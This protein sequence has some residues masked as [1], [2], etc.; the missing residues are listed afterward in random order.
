[1]DI[2]HISFDEEVIMKQLRED[3][4]DDWFP[5]PLDFNDF[6]STGLLPEILQANVQL[7]HGNY[8][9]V[10]AALLNV[11][12]PN[13]TLRYALETSLSD[14]AVYHATAMQ[15]LPLFDG[16]IDWRVFSHRMDRGKSDD[17]GHR[18]KIKYSFRNGIVAWG[19]FLGSVRTALVPG[20]VLL[21]TDLANY[22]EN[23]SVEALMN[24][25]IG[26]LPSLPIG[27]QQQ[28]QVKGQIEQTFEYLKSWTY[29]PDRGLPQNRDASSFLANIYMRTVDQAMIG[30]GYEYFRYMDDIKIICPDVPSARLAL[31]RLIL[32]LRPIG[33]SVNSGKTEIVRSEEKARIDACLAGGSPEMQRISSAW[34]TK[35]LPPITR[36]FL[37]LKSL[38]LRVLKNGEFGSREFRFCIRRLD[39]LARCAEFAVPPDY[40]REI[41]ELLIGGLDIAPAATDEICRYLRSVTLSDEAVAAVATHILDPSHC[42]YN[43]KNYRIWLLLTQKMVASEE[44]L[45]RARTMIAEEGDT[46]TRAGASIYLGAMGTAA[47]RELIAEDFESVSSFLGQRSALIAVHELHFRA[48]KKQSVSI[49]SHIKPHLRPDLAGVYKALARNGKYTATLEP[50][51]LLRF[52]DRERDY[53]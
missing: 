43:W 36:S 6:M 29:S 49:E 3:L 13:F 32:A 8:Q 38:A 26:L 7:N 14:R 11:P 42:I 50:L 47:D 37:P 52:V 20:S 19:D 46:P 53:D 28:E 51:S 21:S 44:L 15:L 2:G 35:S 48:G 23:I 34:Q 39:T 25:M 31:K 40:F 1:M 9:P 17:T 4:R 5:D 30:E 27:G 16:L 41:T 22:F 18:S 10:R 45:Q 24:S 12:K 33:Q